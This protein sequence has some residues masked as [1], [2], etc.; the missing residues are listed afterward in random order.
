MAAEPWPSSLRLN[1]APEPC[2]STVNLNPVPNPAP[3]A[4]KA[5]QCRRRAPKL[6][7]LYPQKKAPQNDAEIHVTHLVAILA[8]AS[9][10]YPE[11]RRRWIPRGDL[12]DYTR[13]LLARGWQRQNWTA[14]GKALARVARR[15]RTKVG[16]RLVTCYKIKIGMRETFIA[17]HEAAAAPRYGICD[18]AVLRG[19]GSASA[20]SVPPPAIALFNPEYALPKCPSLLP[21]QDKILHG[22]R[23][24]GEKRAERFAAHRCGSGDIRIAKAG[25]NALGLPLRLA[26]CTINTPLARARL[27]LLWPL[28]RS[29]GRAL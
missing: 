12:E 19:A 22:F 24:D 5:P 10:D 9:D 29:C 20:D 28:K 11:Q 16:G 13:N 17:T 23:G 14:M 18:C 15:R 2:A 8:D 21:Y 4:P 25:D 7:W 1:S 26:K 27:G 3:T 6:V